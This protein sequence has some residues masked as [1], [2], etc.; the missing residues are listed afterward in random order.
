MVRLGRSV[1]SYSPVHWY[2]SVSEV[3]DTWD[4]SP[5][6]YSEAVCTPADS[7]PTDE[8]KPFQQTNIST[9]SD[10]RTQMEGENRLQVEVTLS[11]DTQLGHTDNTRF[12]VHEVRHTQHSETE[13]HM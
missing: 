12:T 10:T 4:I 5:P 2:I 3:P 6:L 9:V 13:L 11:G 1:Q 7:I 8:N